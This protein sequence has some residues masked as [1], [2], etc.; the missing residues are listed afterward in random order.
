MTENLLVCFRGSRN[1]CFRGSKIIK[2]MFKNHFYCKKYVF[3]SLNM[4][5]IFFQS[6]NDCLLENFKK[7]QLYRCTPSVQIQ[8]IFTYQGNL[9]EEKL[10]ND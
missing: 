10:E 4:N 1:N 8:T 7:K 5:G 9:Y 6:K 3:R 2:K